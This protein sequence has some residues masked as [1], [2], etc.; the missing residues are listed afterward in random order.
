MFDKMKVNQ[1]AKDIDEALKAVEAKHNISIARG[2]GTY[3]AHTFS[4]KVNCVIKEASGEVFDIAARDFQRMA[5]LYGLKADDLGKTFYANGQ[6]YTISGLKSRNKKYPILAK[7][8]N[9]KT[10][11]FPESSVVRNLEKETMRENA[12]FA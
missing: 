9:G 8:R 10:Y 7:N 6:P 11:K 3:D 4:L 1:V 12:K 2:R 5:H